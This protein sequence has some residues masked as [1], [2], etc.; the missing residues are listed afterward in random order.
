MLS[1]ETP[2]LMGK[3]CEIFIQELAY[4]AW[5]RA[6]EA[7]KRTLQPHD[8]AK[9]IMQTDVFE[10][11]TDEE[12]VGN[13]VEGEHAMPHVDASFMED[14]MMNI[15]LV[16]SGNCVEENQN[17]LPH[18]TGFMGNPTMNMDNVSTKNFAEDV[19]PH[20]IGLMGIPMNMGNDLVAGN[21]QSSHPSM[22]QSQLM[23]PDQLPY[24]CYPN[25]M[26]ERS[27]HFPSPSMIQPSFVPL[28]QPPYE[29]DIDMAVS[30]QQS[31]QPSMMQPPPFM[32]LD[33]LPLNCH[34]K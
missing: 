23:P 27:S 7:N 14:L 6:E 20:A 2:L 8:V 18:A 9:T 5:M 16:S 26:M 34:P 32:P 25:D 10:F 13:I 19:I 28:D 33:Q 30:N 31:V 11:L 4:R 17:P 12:D 22:M 29:S 1:A 21:Q 3:A 24:N 15:G